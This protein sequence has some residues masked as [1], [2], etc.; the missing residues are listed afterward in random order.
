MGIRTK[1]THTG[2]KKPIF[3]IGGTIPLTKDI[4]RLQDLVDLYVRYHN[5]NIDGVMRPMTA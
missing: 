5:Q 3:Q 1:Q 4:D 2:S